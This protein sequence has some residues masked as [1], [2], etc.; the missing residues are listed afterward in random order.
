M[1]ASIMEQHHK[2]TPLPVMMCNKI[3]ILE[4]GLRSCRRDHR[5]IGAYTGK[6]HAAGNRMTSCQS[7]TAYVDR[8]PFY[9]SSL[10]WLK[11]FELQVFE[12]CGA[13][14]T[15]RRPPEEA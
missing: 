12:R 10:S 3:D 13:N 1:E 9:S 2:H 8:S 7:A 11:D 15:Q 6:D 4:P 14:P 5:L